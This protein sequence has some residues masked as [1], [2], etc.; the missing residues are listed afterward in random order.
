[1]ALQRKK[2]GTSSSFSEREKGGRTR[3]ERDRDAIAR[4]EIEES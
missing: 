2:N 3:V 1:M 4:R